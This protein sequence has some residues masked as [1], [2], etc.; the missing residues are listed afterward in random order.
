MTS[1]FHLWLAHDQGILHRPPHWDWD[2]WDYETIAF[3]LAT[4]NGFSSNYSSAE[5]RQP[6]IE[7]HSTDYTALLAVDTPLYPTTFR[8]P[9]LPYLMRWTYQI[10]GRN[11]AA[12]RALNALALGAAAALTVMLALEQGGV[13]LAALC[14]FLAL[15]DPL[16]GFYSSHLLTEPLAVFGVTLLLVQLSR[17]RA[18]RIASWP[19]IAVTTASIIYLRSLF[20]LWLP[21]ILFALY[22]R[23][24]SRR[25]LLRAAS[26]GALCLLLLT[27]WAI[28]CSQVLGTVS[29]FGSQ[30]GINLLVD[31]SDEMLRSHGLW[32]LDDQRQV[33]AK[34]GIEGH[35]TAESQR[36]ANALGPTVARA[37]I[38]EHPGALPELAA[39]K[40]S[41]LWWRDSPVPQR[42]LII[43]CL[44][45]LPF[46][47]RNVRTPAVLFLVA[48][49][50]AVALTHNVIN[51]RFLLPLHS[52]LHL[53]SALA[54]FYA[55]RASRGGRGPDQPTSKHR[56]RTAEF[57]SIASGSR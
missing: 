50:L 41:S 28:R 37:W 7:E 12:V 31:Y 35:W 32:K 27:P 38:A 33:L 13:L 40:V 29:P 51:G 48:N 39:L 43:L 21:L 44:L 6:Y 4:G 8:A 45:G 57:P 16:L 14:W 22:L 1:A 30:G 25:E 11:F 53:G 42:I 34:Y 15:A 24:R 36:R 52:L 5:F 56:P 20:A 9:A 47:P 3:S 55:W 54:L 23:D 49:T 26:A 2:E 17:P 19:A 46:M 18:S 10:A